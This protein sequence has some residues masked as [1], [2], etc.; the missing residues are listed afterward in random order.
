[1]LEELIE[2]GGGGDARRLSHIGWGCDPR[3]DF[4]GVDLYGREGGGGA[5]VRSVYGSVVIA[6]GANNDLGGTS[7]SSV[8]VDLATRVASVD[9]RRPAGARRR[10]VRAARAADRSGSMSVRDAAQRR[11]VCEMLD[12]APARAV[13][14]AL[15]GSVLPI[16]GPRRYLHSGPPLAGRRGAAG[17]DARGR[18]RRARAGGRSPRSARGR[19]D[20]RRRRRAAAQRP[21]PRRDRRDGGDHL[22]ADPGAGRRGRRRSTRARAAER[23]TRPG[24]A[25]RLQ[26]RASCSTGC[27]G[28]ATSRRRCS[29]RRCTRS[30][31]WTS[32][33]C[34]PRGC[35]AATSATTATSPAPPPCWRS[36]RP[37]IVRAA[38]SS[39]VAARML[40]FI[41]GNPHFF[42]TF[43]MAAGKAIADAAHRAG[44]D[45][46]VTGDRRQRRRGRDPRV[47]RRTAGPPRRPRVGARACSRATPPTTPARCSATRSSPRR[48]A[49]ERS[50]SS[51]PRRSARSSAPT[52]REARALVARDADDLS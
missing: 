16:V 20:P 46:L 11:R 1:M 36:W 37:A 10:R 45:G 44:A 40:E 8:H 4:N 30:A 9:G 49:W 13:G 31:V 6:F 17:T 34:K 51:P 47:R 43:S 42:L 3:A 52:P 2:R 25:V 22:A 12:T 21:R 27:A 19:R 39:E 28:S 26:R 50:R 23:G 24:T 7:V 38:P 15:A 35:A 14:V 48:S 32:R 33:R 29:T 18:A 5:D 41:A